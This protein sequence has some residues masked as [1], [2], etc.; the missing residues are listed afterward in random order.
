MSAKMRPYDL[1][2]LD[3]EGNRKRRRKKL[4][5]W[6]LPLVVTLLIAVAWLML[7]YVATSQASSALKN[8]DLDASGVW[9]KTLATN[10]VFETYKKPFNQAIV[11]THQHKF[12]EA[13]DY[14]RQSIALA[15]ED[16]KCFIRLQLVLSLE[17]AG[18]NLAP[19]KDKQRS[20]I[21]YTRAL[22]EISVHRSCFE[23][24]KEL[25][26]RVASKLADQ[27]NSVKQELYQDADETV[28]STKEKNEL[29]SDDQLKDLQSLQQQGQ[30][31]KR[32]YSRKTRDSSMDVKKNW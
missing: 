11:A 23:K 17:L 1:R 3:F 4:F 21:Y 32:D 9:L 27:T 31:Y 8:G 28:Q 30:Q 6:S 26:Q 5:I 2:K 10:N 19:Q 16:E 15:P 29:P 13:L 22:S 25:E 24:H 20:I 12:D 7:P 14:F 18:D